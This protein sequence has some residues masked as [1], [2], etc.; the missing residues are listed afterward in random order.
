VDI[1][2]ITKL[3]V[4]ILV[5]VAT[6]VLGSMRVIDGQAVVAVISGVL[7]YVYGNGHGVISAKRVDTQQ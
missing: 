1:T 4:C 2:G 6:T 3:L 7:G 5:V